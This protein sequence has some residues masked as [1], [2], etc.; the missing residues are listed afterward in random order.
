ME[1]PY[2]VDTIPS[3]DLTFL[4]GLTISIQFGSDKTKH[5]CRCRGLSLS[6]F[7]LIQTPVSINQKKDLVPQNS[8]IVRYVYNG[9]VMGFKANIIQSIDTPFR[10]IFISY[11]ELIDRHTLRTC[12][13]AD[14]IIH[15]QFTLADKETTVIIRDLS[16]NGCLLVLDSNAKRTIHLEGGDQVGFLSF[17]TDISQE[18]LNIGCKIMR[19]RS[20][21]K[22]TELG[23]EFDS[24]DTET[25]DKITQYVD[26]ILMILA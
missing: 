13:R 24:H 15:A 4:C 1:S 23:I 6:K 14:V 9:T 18:M 12:E 16:C 20:D 19:I 21:K 22:K 17:S 8:V 26:H 2:E 7:I 25:L 5:Y 3:G 11:P 10:L